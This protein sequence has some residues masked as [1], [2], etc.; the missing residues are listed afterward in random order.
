MEGGQARF[1]DDVMEEFDRRQGRASNAHSLATSVSVYPPSSA[2]HSPLISNPPRTSG[3]SETSPHQPL[4]S[5]PGAT[6]L[7]IQTNDNDR[8][9]SPPPTHL[10]GG[11]TTLSATNPDPQ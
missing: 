10:T 3:P 8:S 11:S 1:T 5:P 7:L 9:Q 6:Q 2:S 4:V